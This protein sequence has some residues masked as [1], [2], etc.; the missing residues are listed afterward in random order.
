MPSENRPESTS[1]KEKKRYAIGY[2]LF[3]VVLVVGGLNLIRAYSAPGHEGLNEA[4]ALFGV[5]AMVTG[6]GLQAIA[7]YALRASK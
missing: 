2:S 1:Q 7:Y 5:I 4:E 3:G 6:L